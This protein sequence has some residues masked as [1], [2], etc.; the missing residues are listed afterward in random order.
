[1]GMPFWEV[2][3]ETGSDITVMTEDTRDPGRIIN[4]GEQYGSEVWHSN[5]FNF[6][7][8][9]KDGRSQVFYNIQDHFV[10]IYSDAH[11]NLQIETWNE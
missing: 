6:R 4:A 3:N 1:M 2:I 11:G 7:V 10:K 9:T 8:L 5:S